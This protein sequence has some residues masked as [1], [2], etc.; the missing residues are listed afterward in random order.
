MHN[1]IEFDTIV[2]MSTLQLIRKNKGLIKAFRNYQKRYLSVGK[3][4]NITKS[5]PE[6]LYRTMRLEG[7]KVTRKQAQALFK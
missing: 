2:S 5:L 1:S 6:V 3:K 4:A 7:E